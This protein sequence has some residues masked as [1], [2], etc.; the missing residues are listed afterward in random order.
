MALYI[1]I[2]F[3]VIIIAVL[4]AF[5]SPKIGINPI[6]NWQQLYKM[7]SVQLAALAGTLV[8]MI[9]LVDQLNS[10]LPEISSISAFHSL[11]SSP[12]YQT[13]AAIVSFAAILARSWK[14]GALTPPVIA[15]QKES[16]KDKQSGLVS[17]LFL[18]IVL[19]S[20]II[21]TAIGLTS[22]ATTPAPQTPKQAIVYIEAA[23]ALGG[24][25]AHQLYVN[26]AITKAEEADVLKASLSVSAA[27]TTANA[28]LAS[29]DTASAQAALT[30]VAGDVT[31]LT[32]FIQSHQSTATP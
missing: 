3:L 18:L 16:A 15:E 14:Q 26:K 4:F 20:T 10:Q 9:P 7:L 30:A 12:A 8:T 25:L 5:K 11:T 23:A 32:S 22:C 29:G 21:L 31:L 6:D 28:L 27:V 17:P 13:F 19:A 2:G 1:I 24:N